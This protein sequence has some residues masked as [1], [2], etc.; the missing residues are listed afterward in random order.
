MAEFLEEES[1]SH[2]RRKPL[3]IDVDRATSFEPEE[4]YLDSQQ[5]TP[6]ASEPPRPIFEKPARQEPQFYTWEDFARSEERMR[7][8]EREEEAP[9]DTDAAYRGAEV[10]RSASGSDTAE[11]PPYS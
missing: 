5:T 8:A 10:Q 9:A 1:S 4:D 7:N 2:V 3:S 11:D 6:R